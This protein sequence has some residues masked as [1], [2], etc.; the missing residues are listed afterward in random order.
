V[1]EKDDVLMRF[2]GWALVGICWALVVMAFVFSAH[3][4]KQLLGGCG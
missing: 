3:L 1:E 2:M 4:A